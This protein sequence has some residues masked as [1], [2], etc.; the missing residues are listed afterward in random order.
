M[1]VIVFQ[2][3]KEGEKK[4]SGILKHAQDINIKKIITIKEPLPQIIDE[5]REYISGDFEADLILD[6]LYHQDLTDFLAGIA[7]K[8]GI[9][10]I[11]S[12]RKA[13]GAI[14]PPTCCGLNY[15]KHIPEYSSQ[16]GVPEIS[17]EVEDG[18][19][20]SVKVKKGAPCGATWEAAGK[21]IGLPVEDA[22]H[23]FALEVQFICRGYAGYQ[24]SQSKRAPL[25]FA[26]DIHMEAFKKAM[27]GKKGD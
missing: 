17:M 2:R 23:R 4:I 6:Y 14:M 21:I 16:F 3:G 13:L 26:G 5:P 27:K 7:Q 20:K 19:I 11:V 10:L 9:P 18:K 25:H 1:D 8:K 12:G 15:D 24:L 22:I